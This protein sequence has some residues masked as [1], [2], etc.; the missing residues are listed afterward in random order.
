[1]RIQSLNLEQI[2]KVIKQINDAKYE[3]ALIS[4]N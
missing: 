3:I 2:K 4:I 1:M